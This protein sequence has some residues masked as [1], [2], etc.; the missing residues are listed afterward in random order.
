MTHRGKIQHDFIYEMRGS[1]LA[2]SP[3]EQNLGIMVD[4]E[5]CEEHQGKQE[6]Q[7]RSPAMRDQCFVLLNSPA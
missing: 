7:Q 4:T 3:W 6:W 2:L 5:R 1:G